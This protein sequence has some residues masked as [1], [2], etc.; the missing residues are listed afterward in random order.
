MDDK[1]KL[2]IAVGAS[3]GANCHPCLEYNVGKALAAGIEKDEI[4]QAVSIAKKVRG[5]AFASM[6][7]LAKKLLGDGSAR[8][9]CENSASSCCC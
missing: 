4:L 1:T 7:I 5:G 3:V 8:P 2:L 6:D 9:A